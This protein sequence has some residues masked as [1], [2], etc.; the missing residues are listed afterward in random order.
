[1]SKLKT[2]FVI[3]L[4]SFVIFGCKTKEKP[5]AFSC[6]L[7]NVDSA[8]NQIALE[9]WYWFCINQKTKQ[10][11]IKFLSDSYSC[12]RDQSQSCKWFGTDALEYERAEQFYLNQGQR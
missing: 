5:D 9:K 12:I 11:K 7:I 6:V 10:E 8:G 1:M 2:L 4:S 3:C